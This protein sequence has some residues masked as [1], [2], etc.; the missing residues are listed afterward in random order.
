MSSSGARPSAR[1][2]ILLVRTSVIQG[3]SAPPPRASCGPLAVRPSSPRSALLSTAVP[4]ALKRTRMG[5]SASR[6][7]CPRLTA[8][9]PPRTT[10]VTASD[11]R[12][13]TAESHPFRA[14]STSRDSQ[15][16]EPGPQRG[17]ASRGRRLTPTRAH[18][19]STGGV[20][21]PLEK[22]GFY[23]L[24]DALPTNGRVLLLPERERSTGSDD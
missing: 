17:S 24:F 12:S 16:W 19:R 1:S 10:A 6:S 14:S 13:V 23:I 3:W 18:R 11:A 20:A 21:F 8:L 9:T 7:G 4:L 15:P 5:R 22:G 2:T